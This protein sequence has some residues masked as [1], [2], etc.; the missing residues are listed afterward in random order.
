MCLRVF[1]HFNWWWYLL[2]SKV[3]TLFLKTADLSKITSTFIIFSY[4]SRVYF[5]EIYLCVVMS[6]FL[7][8]IYIIYFFSIDVT[9]IFAIIVYFMHHCQKIRNYLFCI[10]KKRHL[11]LMCVWIVLYLCAHYIVVYFGTTCWPIV[12]YFILF[13][14]CDNK[15]KLLWVFE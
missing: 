7:L 11:V 6:S 2:P 14:A 8:F 15:L 12:L 1:S 4:L 3:Q 13:F 10:F 5:F 9:W